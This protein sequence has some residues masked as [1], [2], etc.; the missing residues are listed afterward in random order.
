MPPPPI[1]NEVLS[2]TV[3]AYEACGRN[4]V[5]TASV[6]GIARQTLQSRLRAAEVRGHVPAAP[7]PEPPMSGPERFDAAFWR[8][9]AA[10]ARRE[11]DEAEHIAE[12]L[13]GLRNVEWSIPDWISSP[14]EGDRG[15]S[16]IGCLVSDMHM[17]E[18]ISADELNGTNA[19]DPDICRARMKRYFE[20]ACIVG[21]RWAADTDCEGALLALGGDMVSGSI[22]EEL[23]ATN[24]LTSPEQVV[25]AVETLAAG[26]IALRLA[27]KRVHIVSVPGNHSRT[28]HKSTAKLYSRLSYDTMIAAMLAERFKGDKQITFQYGAAKDQIVPVFGRTVF[29]S[30]G[31]K[32]G[33]RGGMGFAG[34]MLP[35]VRGTKKIEAQQARFGRRPDLILHGHYHT[36][37]N[38]GAV[39]SNGSVPGYG[40]YADD[41]RADP[42][43]PAQWLFLLHSKWFLRERAP[44]QL[45]EPAQI[46]KPR[47]RVPAWS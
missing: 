9:K 41:I 40:E 37:G 36:T 7:S 11:A 22:H 24:A 25:A 46:E 32:M 15:R 6:L 45:E 33:S 16:V 23:A 8:K 47:I 26:V 5:K 34:P 38:A 35:I 4:Q 17:G 39:L 18:V 3:A 43:T 20:A 42:E 13:A 19:F 31:D 44:I 14:A 2:A 29:L 27:Y 21:K 1:P 28:T 30:H 10:D 12:Q